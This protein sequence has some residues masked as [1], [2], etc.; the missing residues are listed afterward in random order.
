[1]KEILAYLMEAYHPHTILLYGSFADG[2]HNAHS[3]FDALVIT[4]QPPAAH[5]G[6]VVD[7]V[8]LD[9]F[10]YPT[11]AFEGAVDY[12]QF[13]HLHDAI[14]LVDDRGMGLALRQRASQALRQLPQ[15]SRAELTHQVEWCEKMLLRATRGDAEGF[16]RWHW[17]LV[18]SLEF[19]FDL[20]GWRYF[21]PKKAL[22][23]LEAQDP[24]GFALYR[25]A[26]SS[27]EYQAV[28]AWVAHL[29]GALIP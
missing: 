14:I 29:R 18:D 20:R 12:G 23:A 9:V 7:G 19:Y 1:M 3:D 15:K 10:L 28:G 26:L 24:Q 2:S 16:F 4:D 13:L 8:A 21:G 11:S 6:R 25:Q 5:D 27:F 17:L 22:A